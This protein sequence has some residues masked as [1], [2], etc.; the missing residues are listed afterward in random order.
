MPDRRR[1]RDSEQDGL[2]TDT[3]CG[4][5]LC[6]GNGNKC[7]NGLH[8]LIANDCNSGVCTGGFC[9]VPTCTDGVKNGT[10]TGVD[11]GGNAACG[12]CARVTR[13]RVNA[14]CHSNSCGV[15]TPL[16]CD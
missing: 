8:C 12:G 11:C 4:G 10:E 6:D 7:T 14:D 1:V 5:A 9:E 2:E 15:G 16:V 3:D 13:A